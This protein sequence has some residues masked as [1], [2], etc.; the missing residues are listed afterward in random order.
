MKESLTN[1]NIDEPKATSLHMQD[2]NLSL[3]TVV[4]DLSVEE[5]QSKV[6]SIVEENNRLKGRLFTKQIIWHLPNYN[7]W[8]LETIVQNNVAMKKQYDT[9]MQWQEEVQ[10]VHNL[11]KEKFNK[12]RQYIEEVR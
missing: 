2:K 11:H 3:V 8:I 4:S 9:I 6:E 12:T 1:L 7:K 10:K 5:I